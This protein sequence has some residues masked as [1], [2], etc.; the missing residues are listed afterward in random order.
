MPLR[1]AT[2]DS[3]KGLLR[4]SYL[5]PVVWTEQLAQR[6]K[7]QAGEV[8]AAAAEQSLLSPKV[9]RQQ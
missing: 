8:V 3:R 4:W 7:P 9:A 1:V 6:K 5:L 2:L